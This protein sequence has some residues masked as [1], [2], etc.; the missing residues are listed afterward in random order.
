MNQSLE[1][2]SDLVNANLE[3]QNKLDECSCMQLKKMI[4]N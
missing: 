3:I 2:H 4:N 1:K